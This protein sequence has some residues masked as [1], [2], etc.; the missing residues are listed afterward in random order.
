MSIAQAA[1]SVLRK[2]WE[3]V[4]S[5]ILP[6]KSKPLSDLERTKYITT[7]NVNQYYLELDIQAYFA[8]IV[9]DR[10]TECKYQSTS[11]PYRLTS[12]RLFKNGIE[13]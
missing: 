3:Y 7:I 11:Q 10:D 5:I 13:F 4:R 8:V 2:G 6:S 9:L 12:H 1:A